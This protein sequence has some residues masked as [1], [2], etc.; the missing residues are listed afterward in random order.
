MTKKK[1]ETVEETLIVE[2]T[3]ETV[4]EDKFPGHNTRAF[5]Q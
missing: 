3:V 2:E 5:R 4:V 1:E